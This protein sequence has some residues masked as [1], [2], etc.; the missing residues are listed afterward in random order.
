M[1]AIHHMF[2]TILE[3]IG[4]QNLGDPKNE[5]YPKNWDWQKK[6]KITQKTK[7]TKNKDDPKNEDDFKKEDNKNKG[8]FQEKIKRMEFSIKIGWWVIRDLVF[9]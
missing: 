3:G 1:S 9:H 7:T 2:F 4:C 6:I 8:H 5:D